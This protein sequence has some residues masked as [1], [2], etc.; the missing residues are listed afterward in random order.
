MKLR[1]FCAGE[2]LVCP[3]S[4]FQQGEREYGPPMSA[5]AMFRKKASIGQK[6]ID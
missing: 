5:H 4:F 3:V 6:I 1:A 2:A